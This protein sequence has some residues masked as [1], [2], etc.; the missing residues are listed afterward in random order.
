MEGGGHKMTLIAPNRPLLEMTST[1]KGR[2]P[3]PP[4]RSSS[5]EDNTVSFYRSSSPKE[6]EKEKKRKSFKRVG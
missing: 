2:A 3:S 6:T 5:A 1:K 4:P